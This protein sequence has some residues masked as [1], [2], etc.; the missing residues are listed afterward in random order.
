[1][2]ASPDGVVG[3]PPAG[4][5]RGYDGRQRP[6]P[7]AHQPSARHPSVRLGDFPPWRSSWR[8]D[9]SGRGASPYWA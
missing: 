7:S 3:V 6:G 2:I 4:D 5:E 1:M 9:G 8:S